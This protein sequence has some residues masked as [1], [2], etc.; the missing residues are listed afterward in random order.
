MARK[1]HKPE[2]IVAKPRRVDI[3]HSQG[4]TKPDAIQQIGVT[5]VKWY[6]PLSAMLRISCGSMGA[7]SL[8]V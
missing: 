2:D 8:A 4:V 6:R 5:E 1:R 7:T 3:L